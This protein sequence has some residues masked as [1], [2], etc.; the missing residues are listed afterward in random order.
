[1]IVFSGVSLPL[2]LP[3]PSLAHHKVYTYTLSLVPRPPHSFCHLQYEKHVTVELLPDTS[4]GRQWQPS[5]S[6]LFLF[7]SLP[8]ELDHVSEQGQRCQR[9]AVPRANLPQGG[10]GA[11]EAGGTTTAD[12]AG[13]GSPAS[14]HPRGH[15]SRRLPGSPHAAA[16]ATTPTTAAAAYPGLT[17]AIATILSTT[18]LLPSSHSTTLPSSTTHCTPRQCPAP[19]PH[20][21]GSAPW[22][23]ELHD[24]SRRPLPAPSSG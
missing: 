22:R 23:S 11:A 20:G 19:T 21:S 8:Q 6:L 2:I 14:L 24:L 4:H 10:G 17:A 1:M 12:P 5:P 7:F 18:D 9:P 16:S 13:G 3:Y 15:A